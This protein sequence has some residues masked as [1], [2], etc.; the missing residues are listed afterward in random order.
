M[1]IEHALNIAASVESV[2]AATIDI[3]S[4]PRLTPTVTS[5]ERLDSG[6]FTVGSKARL[7]QPG[8]GAKVWTVTHLEPN[9]RFEWETK[10]AGCRMIG[11]HT[12]TPTTIG[13]RNHLCITIA[14]FG[15]GLIGRL[16]A[17]SIRKALTVEHAGFA[18]VAAERD[19]TSAT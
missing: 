5:V 10:V 15:S 18:R 9:Q 19:A 13:C 8:Q 1:K 14:G 7:K 17:P 12:L 11:T 4:L 16:A 2:W 6:P 3:E